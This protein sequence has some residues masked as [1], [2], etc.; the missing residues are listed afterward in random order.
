MESL[1][2]IPPLRMARI[3]C[4]L[5]PE[6]VYY[7]PVQERGNM[8]RGAF[9][10]KLR[11]LVCSTDRETCERCPQAA[12]CPFQLLFAPR[13]EEGKS[14]GRG[15]P[16][17]AYLI[18]S[19]L[20]EGAEFNSSRPLR[21]ELRLFGSAIES[22][23]TILRP[24][25]LWAEHRNPQRR[26]QLASAFS[27]DWNDRPS[28]QLAEAGRLTGSKAVSLDFG[29]CFA[30]PVY[31]S[32]ATLHYMTPMWLKEKKVEGEKHRK[33]VRI[34]TIEALVR[35]VRSRI[36]LL[37]KSHEDREWKHDSVRIDELAKRARN[38]AKDGEWVD[39]SRYSSHTDQSMPMGGFVGKILCEGIDPALWPLLRIGAEIHAGRYT[40]WGNG[41]YRIQPARHTGDPR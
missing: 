38:L 27:L 13:S 17:K 14:E 2:S 41:W 40:A 4:E 30:K 23:D 36:W 7:S 21:F 18:R 6:G 5:R 32:A 35:E 15:T 31:S 37:S 28:A 16:P 39:R 1:Y 34:P 24:F 12:E 25:A 33:D 9:G 26:V 29:P 8:L 11:Q 3:A 22:A 20:D 19:M 10:D